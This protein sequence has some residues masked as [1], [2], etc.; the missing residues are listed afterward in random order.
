[1]IKLWCAIT[2]AWIPVETTV[3]VRT[4]SNCPPPKSHRLCSWPK[5]RVVNLIKGQ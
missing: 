3:S 2:R 1:M 5:V 4:S